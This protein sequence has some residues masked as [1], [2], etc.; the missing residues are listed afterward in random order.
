MRRFIIAALVGLLASVNAHA[1]SFTVPSFTL[2]AAAGPFHLTPPNFAS[3]NFNVPTTFNHVWYIDP[4][5]GQSQA[6]YTTA[7]VSMNP[8]VTPHQGDITHPWKDI[9]AV[10]TTI[11]NAKVLGYPLP[12]VSGGVIKGGM[13]FCCEAAQQPS[14]VSLVLGL[15]AFCIIKMLH[16]LLS[17]PHLGRQLLLR[18]WL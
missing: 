4:V 10:L 2:G 14:M 6:T 15:V 17:S 5:N 13:K 18:S 12:L 7:G 3:C 11:G 16:L 9:N 1:A 8:S